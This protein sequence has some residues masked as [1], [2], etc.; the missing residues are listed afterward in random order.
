MGTR[1]IV[2][3]G[4]SPARRSN[5][6][7]VCA[8][9]IVA[10][11]LPMVLAFLLVAFDMRT[12][13]SDLKPSR[14][15]ADKETA[16]IGWQELGTGNGRARPAAAQRWSALP[17]ARM[18][19][20]MMD[21][22]QPSQEGSPVT[23][24]ILLPEAGQFLHPAHRVPDQMVE[25]RLTQAVPFQYRRLVWAS[26]VMTSMTDLKQREKAL[27]AMQD[28]SMEPA[29]QLDIADWFRP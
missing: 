20:Y 27:Y 18:L 24:F 2:K 6:R 12:D 14:P 23:M 26:G 1:V 9:I 7:R 16:L 4:P 8:T 5:E 19:G 21:G 11:S 13:L 29:A 10:I 22:Y 28:A 3:R 15:L 25:I 17:R